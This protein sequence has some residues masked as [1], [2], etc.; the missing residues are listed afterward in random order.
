METLPAELVL[1]ISHFLNPAD[2]WRLSACNRRYRYLLPVWLRIK[3][4]SPSSQS[5][6][7][8]HFYVSR[9]D[10]PD[11]PL[12]AEDEALD[13][14]CSPL[15]YHTEYLL[16]TFDYERQNR[17]YLGRHGQKLLYQEDPHYLYTLGL[18]PKDPNQTWK[19]VQKKLGIDADSSGEISE[20]DN[21]YFGKAVCLTVGGENPKPFRPDSS[22]R[23]FL[24]AHTLSMGALWYVIHEKEW[25]IDEDL[26][27]IR[28]SDYAAALEEKR[29]PSTLDMARSI[30]SSEHNG[31]IAERDVVIHAIPS[32]IDGGYSLYSPENLKDGDA[33]CALHHAAIPCH[34]WVQ[35]GI[36]IFHASVSLQFKFGVPILEEDHIDVKQ[37]QTEPL[38]VLIRKNS[39]RWWAIKH[40]FSAAADAE[41]G[42]AFHMD[43]FLRNSKDHE[44]HTV[45]YNKKEKMVL[46]VVKD[47]VVNKAFPDVPWRQSDVWKFLMCG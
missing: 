47:A 36:L 9:A 29:N 6:L 3:L 18:R 2:R 41:D 28:S 11:R 44:D 14:R 33:K 40:Y 26:Q 20:D 42:R 43:S 32:I 23:L 38:E 24:S 46:I 30:D 5:S 12:L 45:V 37:G 4:H 16:W 21:V 35:D 7:K 8:P 17:V 15:T 31:S 10:D 34:F 13:R 27:I 1:N 39:S 25:C 22:T 19:I